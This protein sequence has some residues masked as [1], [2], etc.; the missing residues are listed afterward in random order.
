MA[1]ITH[2]SKNPDIIHKASLST[3]SRVGFAA[4][5]LTRDK[6][7]VLALGESA[8]AKTLTRKNTTMRNF[9]DRFHSLPH[10]NV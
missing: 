1:K 2:A 10:G 9:F 8:S 7:V 4:T 3:D 5:N 6:L